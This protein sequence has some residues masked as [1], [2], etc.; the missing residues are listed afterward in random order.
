MHNELADRIIPLYERFAAE[1]DVDRNTSPWNDRCWI[2]RFAGELPTGATVLDL[3]MASERTSGLETS[4]GLPIWS[5]IER[6][7]NGK[8]HD[9]PLVR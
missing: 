3:G 4:T 7:R 2:E 1:W 6:T 5:E 9:L 8:E